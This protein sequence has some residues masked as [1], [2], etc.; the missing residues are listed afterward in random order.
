MVIKCIVALGAVLLGSL[1]A[2]RASVTASVLYYDT[3]LLTDASAAEAS[4]VT[5]WL[6]VAATLASFFV[7]VM[8]ARSA[9]RSL[10][11]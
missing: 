4:Q 8:L 7:G 11:H 9:Y 1:L 5:L 6:L 3:H 10:P 2:F